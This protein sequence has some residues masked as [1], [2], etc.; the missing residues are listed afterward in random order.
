MRRKVEIAKGLLTRPRV[1]L[2]D[3]PA[4]NLDQKGIQ[5]YQDLVEEYGTEKTI[6]VCSNDSREYGYCDQVINIE[7]Y[8][9]KP[10]S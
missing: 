1:L 4:S 3:E 6:F 7:H 2:L 10:S 5:W 9:I 8:K